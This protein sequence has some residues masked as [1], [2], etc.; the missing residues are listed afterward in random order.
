MN[1]LRKKNKRNTVVLSGADLGIMI[2]VRCWAMVAQPGF[3][4][5]FLVL[6]KLT[7]VLHL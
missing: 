6:K 2:G 5:E 1:H 3:A 7:I 4:K